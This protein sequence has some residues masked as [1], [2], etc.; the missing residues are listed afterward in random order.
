MYYKVDDYMEKEKN[1][2]STGTLTYEDIKNKAECEA[3]STGI[4][5]DT[6]AGA[7]HK[8]AGVTPNI[9]VGAKDDAEST[10]KATVSEGEIEI[11]DKENQKQDLKNLNR[12]TKNSLNKLGEIFDKTKIEERQELAGLFGEIA[13][14]AVGDLA[15]KN[16]W[17]EGSA[18]KNALHALVGGIMSELT[19]SGFLAGASGAMINEMIQD[20][21]SDMFKDDPAMHQWA[22]ALIG[23]VVSQVV[24]DNAQA[25]AGTAS[26]GT[27]NNYLTH[28][29]W[30]DY[31]RE[32]AA[33]NGDKEKEQ[34]VHNK[35]ANID[36]IQDAM[37]LAKKAGEIGGPS[38]EV[39]V[40]L[41][42]NPAYLTPGE[43][44]VYGDQTVQDLIDNTNLHDQIVS[45]PDGSMYYVDEK[46]V[47]TE[48]YDGKEFNRQV[49]HGTEMAIK[50][51]ILPDPQKMTSDYVFVTLGASVLDII[52]SDG[53]YILDKQGNVYMFLQGSMGAGVSLPVSGGYGQGNVDV[54]WKNKYDKDNNNLEDAIG[55]ISY[56]FGGSAIVSA[57][58]SKGFDGGPI[59]VE[60]G[61]VSSFGTTMYSIREA[62][63]IGNIYD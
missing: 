42:G 34:E 57:N 63:L 27:K 37:W 12:D 24:A 44:I 40:D 1:K 50:F 15:I 41:N 49:V 4:N 25:G 45:L 51:E 47:M 5:V 18:E 60:I 31:Q 46:G 39:G 9:G 61:S 20:K 16:G 43:V 32:L 58:V 38:E 8:D 10:T 17:K 22:S 26:S 11:R 33:C 59:T 30:N 35:Y 2:I 53:G 19:D 55:G 28:K 6:S 36:A 48:A 21:L 62:V 54:E 13:Y 23:G 7:E 29:Q 14:K 3:G 56:G 52:S